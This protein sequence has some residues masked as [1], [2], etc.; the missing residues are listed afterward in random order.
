MGEE[1]LPWIKKY[2]PKKGEDVIAQESAVAF[3]KKYVGNY[4]KQK[5]KGLV[6]YGPS[7]CGKTSAV[8]AA[9]NDLNIDVIE[10]NASD[11]RNKD[12]LNAIAGAASKQMSLFM[13]GKLILI[14]EL[15]GIAGRAD[16]GGIPALA[17]IIAES[18]WPVVMTA[19]NPY[20]SKFSKLRNKSEMLQFKNLGVDDIFRILKR[21]C[22]SEKITYDEGLLRMMAMRSAGDARGA[23]ND[24]QIMTSTEKAVNEKT[25]KDISA[26]DKTDTMLSALT[27]IFKTTDPLVAKGAFN[28]V[29]EDLDKCILW[30]DENIPKEYTS[31]ADLARAYDCLS[32]ADVFIGRI[33]RWQHWRY[34]AYANELVT[35]GVAMSKETKNRNFIAYKP[36]GRI[37]KLWWAKQKSVKK[38]AIAAK[39]AEKTHCSVKESIKNIDYFKA[40]FKKNEEMAKKISNELSLNK[41]EFDYLKK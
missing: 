31:P 27:K 24:L 12:Q 36:T 16:Y 9:A 37:L 38:K 7:G 6:L 41:D 1:L 11:V 22:E 35:A 26:R 33:R 21:V 34:L 23:V 28:L 39:I 15:D 10:I 40:I 25:A 14:D 2:C 5:K 30:L 13:R 19:N 8:Y 17:G 18:A 4:K 32:K 3:L 29:N 20:D